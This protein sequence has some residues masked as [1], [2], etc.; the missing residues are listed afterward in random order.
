M[1]ISQNKI[2]ITSKSQLSSLFPTILHTHT[3]HPTHTHNIF[4][5]HILSLT[6]YLAHTHLTV[7]LSHPI[8]LSPYLTHTFSHS[9]PICVSLYRPCAQ[10]MTEG[11]AGAGAIPHWDGHRAGATP[12]PEGQLAG[13][14]EHGHTHPRRGNSLACMHASSHFVTLVFL[15]FS[16]D[17]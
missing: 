8:S 17:L 16:S 1:A 11:D 6:P 5:S 4:C 10:E 2:P 15:S 12:Q 7:T 14:S 3:H 13:A 9:H